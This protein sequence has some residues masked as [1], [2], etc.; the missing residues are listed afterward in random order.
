MYDKRGC[1][2]VAAGVRQ[3]CVLKG[4]VHVLDTQLCTLPL[5]PAECGS[6]M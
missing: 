2:K 4:G 6:E 1:Y 5:R 3:P